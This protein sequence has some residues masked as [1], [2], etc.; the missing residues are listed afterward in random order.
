MVK[1]AKSPD[2]P[3]DAKYLVVHQPYPLNANFELPGDYIAFAFWAATVIGRTTEVWGIHHKPKVGSWSE[4][5]FDLVSQSS[6]SIRTHAC[7]LT[8]HHHEL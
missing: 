8:C 1:R 5:F 2:L 4:V 6:I 7:F 3:D